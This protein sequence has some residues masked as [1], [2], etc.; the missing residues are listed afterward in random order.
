[1]YNLEPMAALAAEQ[2]LA[3]HADE[4]N[5][6]NTEN[7]ITKALLVLSEQG[8]Y[9]FGLFLATRHRPQDRQAAEAVHR[10]LAQLLV[11]TGLATHP[12][13]AIPSYYKR[14]TEQTREE[15][16]VAALQRLLLTKQLMETTLTY[17]RYHAKAHR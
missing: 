11:N 2:M 5:A 16:S 1:M 4:A 12:A 7:L 13:N 8:I 14:I 9:A 15:N 6:K 3:G 10:A 17:G